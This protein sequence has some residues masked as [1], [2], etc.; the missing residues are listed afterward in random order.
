MAFHD[1]MLLQSFESIIQL[2]IIDIDV[3]VWDEHRVLDRQSCIE[4][5]LVANPIYHKCHL[6]TLE[7]IVWKNLAIMTFDD[8]SVFECHDSSLLFMIIW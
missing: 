4:I 1:A 5:I 7:I 8:A 2:W 3:I 6:V